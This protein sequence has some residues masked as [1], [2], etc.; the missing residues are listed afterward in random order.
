MSN[1]TLIIVMWILAAAQVLVL[2]FHPRPKRKF[3][4]TDA[5]GLV[6]LVF[7]VWLT[8]NIL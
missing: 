1:E 6:S 5:I 3:D 7:W 8:L 4:A 2:T